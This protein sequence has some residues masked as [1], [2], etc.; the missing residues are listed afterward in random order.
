[1]FLNFLLGEKFMER[2]VLK[3][4][5]FIEVISGR[6]VMRKNVNKHFLGEMFMKRI[7]LYLFP[8]RKVMERNGLTLRLLN[9][10]KE[11]TWKKLLWSKINTTLNIFNCNLIHC[12]AM[13][14][15]LFKMLVIIVHQKRRREKKNKMPN[16]NLFRVQ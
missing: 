13:P 5:K 10:A 2:R 11:E 4:E 6:K 15:L 12:T 9:E 16:S 3:E 14:T 8:G 7:V 1:M